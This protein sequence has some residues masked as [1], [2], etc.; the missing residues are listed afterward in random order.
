MALHKVPPGN[1]VG[2]AL[3]SYLILAISELQHVP[4]WLAFGLAIMPWGLILLVELEWTYEHYSWLALFFLVVFVQTIH[5]SEHCIEVIQI[6]FFNVPQSKALAIFGLFNVEWVHFLGDSFLTVCTLVLLNKFPRNRWLWVAAL[7][8]VLH[9]SEHTFL[10]FN[11]VF[12][13]VTPGAAGLL[14]SPG[15]FI[16]GGLGLHR[17][18]L[19]WIY[20]ALYTVPFAFALVH[21]LQ[22]TYDA[23]LDAAF[24]AV[25]KSDLVQA[26]HHLESFTYRASET[27]LAPGEDVDRLYIITQGEAGVYG[28]DESGAEVELATLHHGQYFGEIGLLVPNAPHRKVIRAKTDLGVL[29]MDEATFRHLIASSQTTQDAVTAVAEGRLASPVAG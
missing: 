6:H 1:L 22:T 13:H 19:H 29:A 28:H 25:P 8:Q 16:F 26:S 9:Q 5:F 18:D 24:P 4:I 12:N 17:P 15:G 10:I 7:F 20:N 11:Y 21:Q 14:A 27:V 3:V 23:A 2:A